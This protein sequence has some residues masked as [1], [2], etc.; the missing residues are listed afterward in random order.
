ME[1]LERYRNKIDP[2]RTLLF[3]Y[4]IASLYFGSGDFRK[5]I[6]YLNQIVNFK[7]VSLREDIHCFARILNLIAHYEAG[8]DL[9]LEYQIRTTYHFLGKMN[10]QHGVQNE[11]FKFLRKVDQISPDDLKSEFKALHQ[12]LLQ[13]RDHVYERRPFLY[14]DI[15]SWLESKIENRPVQKVIREKFKM[16]K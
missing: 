1:K 10:D 8:E 6:F 12:R 7:D 14:L 16:L 15:L 9:Q 11:I 5:A 13:Y 2:H 4:K 3:Y